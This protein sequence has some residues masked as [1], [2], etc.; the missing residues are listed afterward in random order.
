MGAIPTAATVHHLMICRRVGAVTPV[1]L[2]EVGVG[3]NC[4]AVLA[5]SKTGT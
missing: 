4:G 5:N 2:K 1:A 3:G